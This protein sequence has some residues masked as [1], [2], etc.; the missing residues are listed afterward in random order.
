[1]AV[2]LPQH[3]RGIAEDLIEHPA[4][5]TIRE[6]VRPPTAAD[7]HLAIIVDTFPDGPHLIE[8]VAFG[9]IDTGSLQGALRQMGM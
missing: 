4:V 8:G 9:E 2:D 6:D 7:D 1:M 5:R 3:D